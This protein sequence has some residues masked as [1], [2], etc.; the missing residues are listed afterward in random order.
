MTNKEEIDI[1]IIGGQ[2][3]LTKEEEDAIS[4]FIR[5][6]KVRRHR[7]DELFKKKIDRNKR[8]KTVK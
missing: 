6:D 3:P 5:A 7:V 2:E 1:D 8:T 4:A